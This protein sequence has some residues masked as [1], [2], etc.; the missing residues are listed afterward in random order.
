M[1]IRYAG[2]EVDLQLGRSIFASGSSFALVESLEFT[3][4]GTL[5]KHA[6]DSCKEPSAKK[7]S[8]SVLNT[9]ETELRLELNE[10]AEAAAAAAATGVTAN[11]DASEDV[12]NM[13]VV[14]TFLVNTEGERFQRVFDAEGVTRDT[15]WYTEKAVALFVINK[16]H[17]PHALAWLASRGPQ[18]LEC[19][20]PPSWKQPG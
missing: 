7:I 2:S 5:C 8:G 10:R 3:K 13:D 17:N 11:L 14:A 15:V 19:A 16:K 9:V 6:P 20:T 12:N 18:A 1:C 4:Y